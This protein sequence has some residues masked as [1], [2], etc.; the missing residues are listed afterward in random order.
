MRGATL[1]AAGSATSLAD[2]VNGVCAMSASDW[3]QLFI[4]VVLVGTA[5]LIRRSVVETARAADATQ[6]GAWGQLLAD[7]A[8]QYAQEEMRSDMVY[9]KTWASL[10]GSMQLHKE[11][12]SSQKLYIVPDRVHR[13]RRRFSHFF[14]KIR[15]LHDANIISP[16]LVKSYV[17]EAMLEY[18]FQIIEP[19]EQ[20]YPQHDPTTFDLM[21]EIFKDDIPAVRVYGP[22]LSIDHRAILT[23]GASEVVRFSRTDQLAIPT[24][25]DARY[26]K[27]ILWLVELG[28]L[29][30]L[31][32]SQDARVFELTE[33]GRQV[34]ERLN[35][36]SKQTA[37]RRVDAT[38]ADD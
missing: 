23:A 11:A 5:W 19:L 1:M 31:P 28:L 35:D 26:L 13:A 12:A 30:E 25:Y 16:A 27:V 9:L 20:D 38:G 18:L 7:L 15:H 34:A 22:L 32:P 4:G 3:I 6:K 17:S 37:D 29:S 33:H 2:S 24:M 36:V 8:D 21:R 10:P 14:H